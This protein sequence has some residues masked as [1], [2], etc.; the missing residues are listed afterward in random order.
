MIHYKGNRPNVRSIVIAIIRI[1]RQWPVVNPEFFRLEKQPKCGSEIYYLG[2]LQNWMQMKR[3]WIVGIS[4]AFT[5][6]VFKLENIGRAKHR[7]KGKRFLNSASHPRKTQM[8]MRA[9]L[10]IRSKLHFTVVTRVSPIS[11]AI[12]PHCLSVEYIALISYHFSSGCESKNNGVENVGCF[13]LPMLK[14]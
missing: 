12:L 4:L 7:R 14:F 3:N 8:G 5:L 13:C 9:L 10:F 6:F 1:L 11:F 2:F